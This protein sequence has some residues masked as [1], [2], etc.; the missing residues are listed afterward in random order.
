MS[1]KDDTRGFSVKV[2]TQ[3][4]SKYMENVTFKLNLKALVGVNQIFI[5]NIQWG[6][7]VLF[8]LTCIYRGGGKERGC[9]VGSDLTTII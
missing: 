5:K 3:P 7:S 8:I 9:Y 2:T 6:N 4:F 1:E